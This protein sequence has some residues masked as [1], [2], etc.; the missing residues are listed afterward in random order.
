[1]RTLK[2][3]VQY[4]G[5]QYLGWQLQPTGPT[6][7]Q[8]I[9]E[10]IARVIGPHRIFAAGRTDAGV[11]ALGQVVTVRTGKAMPA[12]ELHRALNGILPP[13]IAVLSCDVVPNEF[14]P[15]RDALRK[16]YRYRF[17]DRRIRPVFERNFVWHVWNVD[18]E[19]MERAIP[20]F[21]GTHDFASFQGAGANRQ[22]TP[23]KSGRPKLPKKTVRTIFRMDL[24]RPPPPHES[25][26]WLEVEGNGFLKQMV[27]N[28][29]GSLMQVGRGFREPEWIAEVLAAKDRSV[30]GPTAPASGL[31]LVRVEYALPQEP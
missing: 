18:W 29:V 19:R 21:V 25:E 15:R 7:Q 16:L 27:R 13:D 23:P 8:V 14:D 2:L 3:V 1:V 9:E 5:T 12:A 22:T 20:H 31:T 10:A 6:L 28:L 4:E 24:L 26:V 30:A 11:H 17:F